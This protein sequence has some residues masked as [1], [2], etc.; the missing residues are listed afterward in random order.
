MPCAGYALNDCNTMTPLTTPTRTGRICAERVVAA[1]TLALLAASL[2]AGCSRAAGEPEQ[3][4]MYVY[5]DDQR[6][7]DTFRRLEAAC[8]SLGVQ[9]R[10]RVKLEFIGVDVTDRVALA[11]AL[12]KGIERRPAA[13]IANASPVLLE[14]SR[15]T[16]TIP[17]VFV[18]HQDPVELE[19]ADSLS[20]L[21][22]NLTGIS[23][24]IGVEI[25]MLELLRET[26]PRA[27]RIGY[28]VDRDY[29]GN[30]RVRE[31]LEATASRHGL[32]WKLVAL[33]S[34]D[35]LEGDL[36][37]AGPVDAWFVTKVTVLDQNRKKFIAT[38]GATHR[39]AIYPSQGDVRAGGPMAYEAAFDDPFSALARQIDR[40]LTG[41]PPEDVPIERPKRFGLSV[42]VAAARES[43]MRLS[44][45]L[46]SRADHVR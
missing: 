4:V 16:V 17:I 26:A 10:H 20:K 28:L 40:V 2:L 46:L 18:T 44:P 30:P 24:H 8:E 43:G 13:I 23:F 38:L 29:A 15:Q 32:Q 42:N 19:V 3:W 34:I 36:L 35:S 6:S 39:P 12:A 11:A 45:E 41:V 9:R 37:A 14:A 27:R 31:F 33:G 7:R 22:A 5:F 21:P 25:K 1:I